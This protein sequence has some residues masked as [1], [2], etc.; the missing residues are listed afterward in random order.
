M[1][2]KDRGEDRYAVLMKLIVG[3]R[4]GTLCSVNEINRWSEGSFGSS[5]PLT[6]DYYHI[7]IVVV[8]PSNQ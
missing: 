8:S 2:I 5:H 1:F 6:N 3:A 4:G 7:K